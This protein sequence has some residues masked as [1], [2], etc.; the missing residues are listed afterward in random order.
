MLN[1]CEKLVQG[2]VEDSDQ[3]PMKLDFGLFAVLFIQLLSLSVR[4]A[5]PGVT[6]QGRILKPDGSPLEGAS[7]QFRMQVRSPGA[8]NCLLFDEMQTL[9]MVGSAGAFA[10]TLNDGSG[11]RL[12][13]ATYPI[14]RIFANRETM[15]LDSTRCSSGTTYTP[16][17]TDGRKFIVYFK[18]ETMSTF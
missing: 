1:L 7:V 6:Y 5:G 12:D 16:A 10:L 14:S 9:S 4:A 2:L 17:S 13:T 8:E 3:S 15:T 18:D 11:T